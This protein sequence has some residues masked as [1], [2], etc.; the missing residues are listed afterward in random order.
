MVTA[1][2]NLQALAEKAAAKIKSLFS[3]W[4][5]R[6]AERR[7]QRIQFENEM[8]RGMHRYSSKNDDDLPIVR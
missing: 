2:R 6:I 1:P 3:C 4:P 5:Q 8:Y 7:L